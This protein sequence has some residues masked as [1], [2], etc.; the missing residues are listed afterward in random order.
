[1]SIN[2][3]QKF[4]SYDMIKVDDVLSRNSTGT[5]AVLESCDWSFYKFPILPKFLPKFK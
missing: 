4:T 5:I 2:W 1:M 3:S